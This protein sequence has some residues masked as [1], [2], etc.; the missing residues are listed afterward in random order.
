MLYAQNIYNGRLSMNG[1]GICHIVLEEEAVMV[2]AD[3]HFS[4]YRDND[5]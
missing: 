1:M 5:R 3:F 4:N 2:V